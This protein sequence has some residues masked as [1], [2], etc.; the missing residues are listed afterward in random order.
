MFHGLIYLVYRLFNTTRISLF[1][2]KLYGT[3]CWRKKNYNQTLCKESIGDIFISQNKPLVG[4][5]VVN[6]EISNGNMGFLRYHWIVLFKRNNFYWKHFLLSVTVSSKIKK[7][8]VSSDRKIVHNNNNK[9]NNNNN[10]CKL[11]S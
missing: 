1:S 2:R 10:N 7:K 9:P 11:P 5:S 6:F 8:C 4:V 3:G